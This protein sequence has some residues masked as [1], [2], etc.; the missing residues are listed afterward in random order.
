VELYR[1][2]TAVYLFENCLRILILKEYMRLCWCVRYKVYLYVIVM[3]NPHR[4]KGPIRIVISVRG[5]K[6]LVVKSDSHW[7][8][9]VGFHEPGIDQWENCDLLMRFY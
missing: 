2:I 4:A 1:L 9:R 5:F 7:S 8:C 3:P 6:R